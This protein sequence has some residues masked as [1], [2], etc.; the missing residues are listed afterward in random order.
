MSQPELLNDSAERR[1]SERIPVNEKATLLQGHLG[2]ATPCTLVDLCLDGCRV[3]TDAEIRVDAGAR[4]ELVFRAAGTAFR[5][6][7]VTEWTGRAREVG[8]AFREVSPRR[9]AELVEALGELS[10]AWQDKKAER[11]RAGEALKAA[12][13]LVR[14]RT[15]ELEAKTAREAALRAD[16]EQ[17]A[18]EKRE[19]EERLKCSRMELAEAEKAAQKLA[20]FAE[21]EAAA[22]AVAPV[23][24]QDIRATARK[25]EA[26]PVAEGLRQ[27][28]S[29][30]RERRQVQRHG[31]DS[32]AAVL[33]LDVHANVRGRILDVSLGGC[34][35]RF[36]ERFPVGIYR[37]VEVEFLLDGLPFRL[38]GVVQSLHD[39]FT[40]GIRFVDLSERKREQLLFVIEEIAEACEG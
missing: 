5:L 38:P 18:G 21:S 12:Q 14:E 40:V 34:R 16:A 1:L 11:L 2:S 19:A 25:E 32:T 29:S 30:R 22:G 9:E 35:I 37:R 33:L 17:A 3:R 36:E 23:E 13:E 8:V 39:R 28:G 31:V 24:A 4:V 15:V 20:Y 27:A 6:S 7:G 10:A 26:G